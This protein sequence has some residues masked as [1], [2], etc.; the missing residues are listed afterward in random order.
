MNSPVVFARHHLA[1]AEQQDGKKPMPVITSTGRASP[2]GQTRL[3]S[4]RRMN[5]RCWNREVW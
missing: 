5:S 3:T 2:H 1:P 4:A